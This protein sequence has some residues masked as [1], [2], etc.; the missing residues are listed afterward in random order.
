[1]EET[2]GK[3]INKKGGVLGSL[4]RVRVPLMKNVLTPLAKNVLLPLGVTA[5]ASI[6]HAAIQKKVFGSRMTTLIISNEEI[7]DIMKMVKSLEESCQ[8]TEGVSKTTESEIKKGGF[9]V[10]LLGTLG[11]SLLGNMLTRKRVI[12][13]GKGTVKAAKDFRCLLIL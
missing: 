3:I 7:E 1:M 13:T 8:L 4:M 2:T 10:M 12:Q 6:A 9:L 11:A 5:V